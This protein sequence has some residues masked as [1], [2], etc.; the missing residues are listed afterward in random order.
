MK[1]IDKIALAGIAMSSIICGAMIH[2][3]LADYVAAK[4]H[5]SRNEAYWE[6]M[7]VLVGYLIWRVVR[8]LRGNDSVTNWTNRRFTRRDKD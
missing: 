8:T 6:L 4:L 1:P 2:F 5:I 7:A 3:W